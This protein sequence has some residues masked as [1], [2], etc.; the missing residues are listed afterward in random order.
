MARL[1]T[2]GFE[3]NSTSNNIE[4]TNNDGGTSIQT[5]T[6][7]SGVYAAKSVAASGTSR[8]H[9]FHFVS[10]NSTA[11]HFLRAYINIE[12]YPSG[13]TN[14]IGFQQTN[15]TYQAH[16]KL[17]S[18]GELKLHD[19][20]GQIGSNS[21]ALALNTWYRIELRCDQSGGAANH[22]VEAQIDGSTFATASNRTMTAGIARFSIG[23]NMSSEAVGTGTWYWDDIALNNGSGSYQTSYPGAG[24]VVCIR[25]SVAGDA[26]AWSDTANAGGTTNNYTLVDEFPPNDVTDFVQSVV[27]NAEDLYNLTTGGIVST[28][29]INLVQLYARFRNGTA[30]ATT[31]FK[32]QI[33]KDSGGTKAQSSAIIPNSTSWRTNTTSDPAIPMLTLY[34]DPDSVDWTPTTIDTMQA[35][36]IITAAGANS[37]QVSAIWIMIDYISNPAAASKGGT[38]N[39]LGV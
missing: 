2:I 20:V 26:N 31:A 23:A 33:I 25:P 6:V 38:I 12:A 19:I 4:F 35:G 7:R 14:I 5:V 9:R 3:Q 21:S 32:S 1:T 16:I 11:A 36:V 17:T 18:T 13:D 37:I 15:N 24:N 29:T 30:D 28:D 27:L 8:G 10:S 39:L 22:I 34:Q